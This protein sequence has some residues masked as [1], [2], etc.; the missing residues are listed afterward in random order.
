MV[1]EGNYGKITRVIGSVLD[2]EFDEARLPE[3]YHALKVEIERTIL[4]ETR[5]STLWCEVAQHLGGGQIRAIALDSTDGLTRGTRICPPQARPVCNTIFRR[6]PRRFLRNCFRRPCA[7]GF[8]SASRMR[9]S[10]SKSLA[11]WR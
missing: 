9:R 6:S 2:A 5:T 4:G 8:F 10:A 1:S 3:I 7:R 11:W